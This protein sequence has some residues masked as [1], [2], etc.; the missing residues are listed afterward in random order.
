MN[1]DPLRSARS[2]SPWWSRPAASWKTAKSA[3]EA[4]DCLLPLALGAQGSCQIGG[5][6]ATNA[7]GI[8]VLRY[9]MA[10]DLILGLEVVLPDGEVWNGMTGLRKDNRGYDLKQ[11]FIGAEGTLGV[12]TGVEIKLFPLPRRTETAYLGLRSFADAMELF[13]RARAAVGPVDRLRGIGAECL[14]MARIIDPVLV[15]PVDETLPV[16]VILESASSEASICAALVECCPGNRWRA[17]DRA[18]PSS[19]GAAAGQRVLGDP[20]GDGRRP[21]ASRLYVRT[22]LSV[23]ISATSPPCRPRPRVRDGRTPR[24][25]FPGLWP[26]GRRQCPFQRLPPRGWR[27]PRR[28]PPAA[29]SRTASTT[30]SVR[31]AVRSARSTGRPL[32]V[33][34]SLGGLRRSTAGSSRPSSRRSIPHG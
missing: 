33:E 14:P 4:A 1:E 34:T 13:A 10:R 29:R 11:F 3:A 22:D 9:G 5:N 20:R 6:A 31:S 8:N 19:P 26:C 17:A 15:A 18:T 23:P 12:I 27:R 24:G 16:H 7:G 30:S 2:T 32:S 25:D 21:C 28:A